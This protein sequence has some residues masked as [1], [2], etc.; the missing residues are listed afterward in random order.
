M[1]PNVVLVSCHLT[2]KAAAGVTPALRDT[3]RGRA[4][5]ASTMSWV[6]GLDPLLCATDGRESIDSSLCSLPVCCIP[7]HPSAWLC[8]PS[9]SPRIILHPSAPICIQFQRCHSPFGVTEPSFVPA[10][11]SFFL[12]ASCPSGIAARRAAGNRQTGWIIFGSNIFWG[13][14][15]LPFEQLCWDIFL[16][17]S[18][19]VCLLQSRCS[20]RTG[21][22]P[23]H[24]HTR[25]L[26]DPKKGAVG[27]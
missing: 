18:Q 4:A 11:K 19:P 13:P 27:V 24:L 22:W 14:S 16:P 5:P 21:P 8:I 7:L 1:S 20:G 26:W 9:A 3:G 17:A 12:L 2:A 6:P 10:I 25:S 15:G 23:R